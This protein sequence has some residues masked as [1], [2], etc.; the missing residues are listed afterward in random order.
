MCH[1]LNVQ[2]THNTYIPIALLYST[3]IIRDF[4][5]F[6]KVFLSYYLNLTNMYV[7]NIFDGAI[8]HLAGYTRNDFTS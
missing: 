1:L 5:Q 8:P 2:N 6:E 3:Y 4:M 7:N